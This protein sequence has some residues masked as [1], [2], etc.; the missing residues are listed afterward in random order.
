[1]DDFEFDDL[2]EFEREDSDLPFID[3]GDPD[4]DD[5]EDDLYYDI[6][7]ISRSLPKEDTSPRLAEEYE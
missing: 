3:E 4:D 2:M 5:Y 6:S 7:V 1:M